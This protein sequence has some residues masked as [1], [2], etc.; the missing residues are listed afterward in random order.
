MSKNYELMQQAEMTVGAPTVS[1]RKTASQPPDSVPKTLSR[2]RVASFPLADEVVQEESF[3][4]VQTIFLLQAK[5]PPRTVVFAG[6]DSGSGCSRICAQVAR[7]LASQ[8][9][10]TVC[11]VDANLRTPSLPDLFGVANHFGLTDA[12]AAQGAIRDFTRILGPDNLSL[13]SCGSAAATS[14]SL[15]S[16]EM[17]KVRV[18]QL[19]EE[20]DYILIDCPPLNTYNDGVTIAQL[21][22]GLVLVLEA[23]ATRREVAVKVKNDIVAAQINILGAVLNKRTYPIPRVLYDRL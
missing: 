10:G 21:A 6:I 9:L 23:N 1:R 16:S 15:L 5:T 4:L 8:T 3:K 2:S 19:R 13:L 11:L 7:A 22:D 12:L 14:S 20:F 17:L 18:L